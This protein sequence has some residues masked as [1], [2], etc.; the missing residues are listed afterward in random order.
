MLT[1]SSFLQTQ[2]LRA[3]G[4]EKPNTLG[5]I[6]AKSL[7]K[8]KK[9]FSSGTNGSN[10]SKP[11]S[12]SAGEREKTAVEQ[13]AQDKMKAEMEIVFQEMDRD[14]SG[15]LDRDEWLSAAEKLGFNGMTV[16][17]L[18]MVFCVLD[19]SGDGIILLDELLSLVQPDGT[20]E[21]REE[22]YLKEGKV[23]RRYLLSTVFAPTNS[24]QLDYEFIH[25]AFVKADADKSGKLSKAEF[26]NVLAAL[27]WG[28]V[29]VPELELLLSLF[30][31]DGDH[32]VD[33]DEFM[34]FFFTPKQDLFAA[35]DIT[36]R[37]HQL[38]L[39]AVF[40]G[41]STH[42]ELEENLI[43]F[44]KMCEPKKMTRLPEFMLRFYLNKL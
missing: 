35:F 17:D 22:L 16:A 24:K 21:V 38:Q 34:A 13:T 43:A 14:G 26:G 36:N 19:Y 2:V 33:F 12:P 42:D 9:T 6:L 20:M 8:I 37:K 10:D 41:S 27:G 1:I 15:G 7:A 31:T 30:D 29:T 32:Q 5:S 3:P 28:E 4:S 44:Y 23:V 40:K 39:L 11:S 25:K 18:D